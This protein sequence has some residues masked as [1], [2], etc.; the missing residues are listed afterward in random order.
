MNM[1]LIDIRI[2]MQI[3]KNGSED[4]VEGSHSDLIFMKA[5]IVVES[6]YV[7]LLLFFSVMPLC[8]SYSSCFSCSN[9]LSL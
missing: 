5:G 8:F 6:G 4:S 7:V 1:V 2:A 9:M 3:S